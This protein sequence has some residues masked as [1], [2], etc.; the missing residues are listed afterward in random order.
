MRIRTQIG[1]A[2]I[3]R[4]LVC[5]LAGAAGAEQA[6][7]VGYVYPAG[8]QV[9]TVCQVTIGGQS[10]EAV[11]DVFFSGTGL[12][13]EVMDHELPPTQAE[14]MELRNRRRELSQ[15]ALKTTAVS[16]EMAV[17]DR[18]LNQLEKKRFHPALG[19]TVPLRVTI[20][21]TTPPGDYELRVRTRMGLSNPCLFQV[22]R[23]PEV[24]K[25]EGG[26]SEFH[27]ERKSD[28]VLAATTAPSPPITIPQPA[29]V[30]GWIP[31]GGVDRF[32]FHA[33]AGQQLVAV[34]SAR[35]LHPYLADAVPGWVQTVVAFYDDRGRE[36]AY[37]D[38]YRFR[39]DPVLCVSIPADGEYAMEVRDALYR[40]R[41]DFVYRIAL[42]D[43]P[44]VSGIYPLGCRTGMAVNVSLRGW[45]LPARQL[46]FLPCAV[47]GVQSLVVPQAVPTVNP[48]PF[49]VDT[50][51][52]CNAIC[53]GGTLAQAQ[54][55]T[56]PVS[57]NGCLR[58]SGEVQWF[59]FEGHAGEEMVAET[60][61]RRL[62]SPIDSVLQLCDG[63]GRPLALNDDHEDRRMGLMTHHADSYIRTTL[64]SN[65]TYY[66]QLRDAQGKGGFDYAYRL[67][68]HAPQPDFDLRVVPSSISARSGGSVPLTVYA[69][70]QDGFDGGI[71]LSLEGAPA[72]FKL[73]PARVLTNQDQVQ[74]TLSVPT[75]PN[76]EP[77]HLQLQG[78]ASIHGRDIVHPVVPADDLTQAFVYHH[79]VPA[80]EL[81]VV[82]TGRSREVTKV[83]SA[84]PIK[85]R[86]GGTTHVQVQVPLGPRMRKL[87]CEL[88]DPPE[89]IS[90]QAEPE[91]RSETELILVA[92]PDK[93][94]PGQ[95]G[96]LIINLFGLRAPASGST[97][98]NE[99]LRR[100]PLGALPAIPFEVI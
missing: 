67:Q 49:A 17:I 99:R 94:S 33:R 1:G 88:S 29:V 91:A 68:L 58:A 62:E 40:G 69:L 48:V 2:F 92:D 20:A 70:R 50:L 93:V 97:K 5:L 39:P 73:T 71:A 25:P 19:E 78:Q 84:T 64:P 27:P 46:E 61:A 9:G 44:F 90:L 60:V 82:V 63:A 79:L 36:L 74:I 24:R 23:L 53:V 51:P 7:H 13:A 81:D 80:R 38:H 55:V 77:I 26:W 96:S 32:L 37:D 21:P 66:V 95:K 8:G 14:S 12:R 41:E 11:E 3:R 45:N 35:A 56:I 43:L 15:Q 18:R 87:V 83:L 30:N 72:G 10:I 42:G 76:E 6:P 47:A 65:G 86:A 4:I 34:T 89:G 98:S 100:I 52:E 31:P 85:I 54:H 22:G 75:I 28:G 57:I 16:N 59:A